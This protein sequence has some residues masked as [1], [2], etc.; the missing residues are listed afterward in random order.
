M[1]LSCQL[2]YPLLLRYLQSLLPNN[3]WE[4]YPRRGHHVFSY[5][6]NSGL[7]VC[8]LLVDTTVYFWL[9]ENTK[10]TKF[11]SRQASDIGKPSY[12]SFA[13]HVLIVL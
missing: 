10:N 11:H 3:S 1:I 7:I 4:R 6:D 12:G 8:A 9:G 13:I 5:I 2:L